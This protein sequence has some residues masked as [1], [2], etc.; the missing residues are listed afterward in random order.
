MLGHAAAA[1]DLEQHAR[2]IAADAHR[3]VRTG[4]GMH[5]RIVHQ[6]GDRAAQPIRVA[7][8]PR[9]AFGLDVH[10]FAALGQCGHGHGDDLGELDRL[11]R[12]H[13]ARFDTG[14]A[15]QISEQSFDA[16]GGLADAHDEA[17][18]FFRFFERALVEQLR[19]GADGGHG[20]LE[21]VRQ[22]GRECLDEG[23]PLEL[24]AHGVDRTGQP[25]DFPPE[26]DRRRG[27]A[28]ARAEP[29]AERGERF[30]RHGNRAPDPRRR[31]RG[32]RAQHQT[33]DEH[34][35]REVGEQAPHD[36]GRFDHAHGAHVLAVHLDGSIDEHGSGLA[37]RAGLAERE[38][39]VSVAVQH[40]EAQVR[41]AVAF[42]LQLAG[43]LVHG[44]SR[45]VHL[46]FDH[47]GDGRRLVARSL[48]CETHGARLDAVDDHQSETES[49][50]AD[51]DRQRE[52]HLHAD[53]HAA[54]SRAQQA[55]HDERDE[56]DQADR[57]G[58]DDNEA[59]HVPFVA[60]GES[61]TR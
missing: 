12:F 60:D 28:L 22:I 37:A 1:R 48:R 46:A 57:R 54:R 44:H 36:D 56:Q 30:D 38:Q 24:A 49:E 21:L 31:Q 8:D 15:Q 13:A 14:Q 10:A 11:E 42:L 43:D 7:A 61:V 5:E 23:A 9:V 45:A 40:L 17:A 51:N 2:R 19:A 20:V 53:R 27:A 41:A 25:R 47:A 35:R 32:H 58:R 18:R 39:H 4:F 52:E 6:V 29:L 26:P 55:R 34:G 3:H 59:N 16:L 33:D 50:R